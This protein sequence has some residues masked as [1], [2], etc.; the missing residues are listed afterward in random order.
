MSPP[1]DGSSCLLSYSEIGDLPCAAAKAWRVSRKA[2]LRTGLA[3]RGAGLLA[4]CIPQRSWVLPGRREGCGQIPLRRTSPRLNIA[5]DP[6]E[7]AGQRRIIC[8]T[9]FN[10]Q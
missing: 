10:R 9:Y 4:G 6:T 5:P 2:D 8:I 3:F 1:A 7:E